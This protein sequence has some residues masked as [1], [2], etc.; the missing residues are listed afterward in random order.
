MLA[1]YVSGHGFGHA[2]RVAVVLRALLALRPDLRV[3]VNTTA[4]AWLFPAE[5]AYRPLRTDV[6]LVQRDGLEHDEAAT[7]P[8][9]AALLDALPALADAE[10]ARL[11]AGGTRLVLGDIPAL[12]FEVAARLG[13]PGIAMGNFGWDDIYAPYVD[14]WPAFGPL[15][16][17]LRASYARTDLLLRLPFHLPM[18]AFGRREELPVVA[19]CPTLSR[20]AARAALDVPADATLVLLA[21][22]GFD[23][24]SLALE[25]LAALPGYRFVRPVPRP[26]GR[27]LPNLLEVP[28]HGLIAFLDMLVAADAVVTKP[29]YGMVADLLATRVPALFAPRPRFAEYPILR[30]ALLTHARALEIPRADLEA[31]AFGPYLERLLAL[32]HPWSDLSLDG[33]DVAAR[34]LAALL[35]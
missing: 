12:A 9:V 34:R 14:T 5:V 8:L 29:G 19:R 16:E 4:P 33:A 31:A 17:R 25:R 21:F 27:V 11:H 20:A 30:D 28:D 10:A 24:P 13:V 32:D 7:I 6:G 22:G 18:P 26:R 1:V 35:G 2:V 23:V 3:E 15:V